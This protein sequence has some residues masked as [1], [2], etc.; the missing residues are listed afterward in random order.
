MVLLLVRH[1][2]TKAHSNC[3]AKMIGILTEDFGTSTDPKAH[4]LPLGEKGGV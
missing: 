1:E 2:K 4:A 3:T